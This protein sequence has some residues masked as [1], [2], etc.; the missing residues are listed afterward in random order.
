MILATGRWR[1]VAVPTARALG[2]FVTHIVCQ[3]GG[4]VL[5]KDQFGELR[6]GI[7]GGSDPNRLKFEGDEVNDGWKVVH[8][9]IDATAAA[10]WTLG[11]ATGRDWSQLVRRLD[12]AF[13]AA[14]TN[15]AKDNNMLT[16]GIF[17]PPAADAPRT[18]PATTGRFLVSEGY[19]EALER[20][21][22]VKRMIVGDLPCDTATP[23]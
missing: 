8:Q 14:D 5:E 3:D 1:Q 16:Y 12:Q 17:V 4:L 11:T 15:W 7:G 2:D 22:E 10:Q 20:L 19:L 18:F 9:N 23:G 6:A 21:P 13:A